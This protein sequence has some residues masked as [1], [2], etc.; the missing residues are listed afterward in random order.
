MASLVFATVQT[1][2]SSKTASKRR[3]GRSKGDMPLMVWPPSVEISNST[4][5]PQPVVTSY[6]FI[7]CL[8]ITA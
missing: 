7:E 6:L 4:H 3:N 8:V 1:L 5:V 2:K